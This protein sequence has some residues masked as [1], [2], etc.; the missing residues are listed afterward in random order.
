VKAQEWTVDVAA[1]QDQVYAVVDE[2]V[3]GTGGP[4]PR[5]RSVRVR[6]PT[7]SV[8]TIDGPAGP[9]ELTLLVQKRRPPESIAVQATGK[10]IRVGARVDFTQLGAGRTRC[11]IAVGKGKLPFLLDAVAGPLVAREHDRIGREIAR[12]LEEKA[13]SSR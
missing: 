10:G 5:V 8:W 11:H 1:P 12:F 13:K 9:L 4:L 2:L 7:I 3:I 6:T